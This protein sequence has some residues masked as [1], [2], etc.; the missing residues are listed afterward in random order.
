MTAP[1]AIRSPFRWRRLLIGGATIWVLMLGA[2]VMTGNVAMLP[3]IALIGAGVVPLAVVLRYGERLAGTGLILDDLL[4]AFLYGG[5]VGI[6]IGGFMDAEVGR[7]VSRSTSLLSAGL[8]EEAAKAIALLVVAWRLPAR[9]MRAGIYLGAAVGAGFATLET[10]FYAMDGLLSSV[11]NRVSTDAGGVLVQLVVTEVFRAL[12]SPFLHITWTAILGGVIFAASRGTAFQITPAIVGTYLMVAALHGLWDGGI[13]DIAR[14]VA[15]AI[16]PG[17]GVDHR[18]AGDWTAAQENAEG[19]ALLSLLAITLGGWALVLAVGLFMLR[20]ATRRARGQ[21][22]IYD[23]VLE[24]ARNTV[25]VVE[26]I[27]GGVDP[28]LGRDGVRAAR[29]VV[30]GKAMDVV[31]LLAERGGGRRPRQPGADDDDRVLAA[32]GRIHQLHLEAAGVP[33]LLDRPGRDPR[34]QHKCLLQQCLLQR[35]QPASTATGTEQNPTSTTMPMTRDRIF[36][37]AAFRVVLQ[38]RVCSRLQMPWLR[39][40]Q[41][42]PIATM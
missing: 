15:Q 22:I 35:S 18:H 17:F 42:A 33:L 16:D 40:R 13:P 38:P 30:I 8:V 26:I 41:R 4:Y 14:G 3:A 12:L 9:S 10:T 28:S 19:V 39:W 27:L 31:A 21:E 2:F 11:S 20:A 23:R 36:R 29:G 7:H 32:V 24:Q 37:V 5:A 6:L 34:V 25:A 1:L